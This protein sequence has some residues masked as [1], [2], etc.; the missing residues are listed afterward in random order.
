MY[1]RLPILKMLAATVVGTVVISA[2]MVSINWN[3][4]EA[5][6]AAPKIDDLLNVMIVLSSFVFSLVMV[7]LGYALWK[8]KAK[9]GDESDGEP[10]HGNTRLEIAWT[11]IPTVI[12]LF[13]AGYSWSILN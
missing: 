7:M 6:T 5:S 13:A 10:I 12:V 1:G 2:V 9:P 8:F 3:G 11:L 4:Q